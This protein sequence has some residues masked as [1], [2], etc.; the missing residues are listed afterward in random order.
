MLYASNKAVHSTAS[1][2]LTPV[3]CWE[4]TGAQERKMVVRVNG[5]LLLKKWVNY[6]PQ[7]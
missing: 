3:F 1:G 2:I 5:A 4:K 6:Q 7:A